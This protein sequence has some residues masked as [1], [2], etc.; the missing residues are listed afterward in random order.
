MMTRSML[1]IMLKCAA[2]AQVP[3]SDE[4]QGKATPGL[5]DIQMTRALNGPPLLTLVTD[6]RP[7]D[8]YVVVQYGRRWFWIADNDIQSKYTFG[9]VML[10][11]S[12]ADTGVRGAAPIVTI[13]V[14]Q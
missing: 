6:T 5:V 7:Q 10:L 9:I 3:E 14:N 4:M 8:S 13:P 1:Q 11:F 2:V 12:I